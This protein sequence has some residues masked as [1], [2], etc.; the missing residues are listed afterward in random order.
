VR[1]EAAA[2]GAAETFT[3][4]DAMTDFA[5]ARRSNDGELSS[6]EALADVWSWAP[7]TADLIMR[8]PALN[9]ESVQAG[10][11]S[12]LQKVDSLGAAIVSGPAGLRVPLWVVT[13]LAVGTASEIA[14]RRMRRPGVDTAA[15]ASEEPMFSLPQGN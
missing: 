2:P 9:I 8:P 5:G 11:Q 12:F 10:V 14:R 7:Q 15:A 13:A 1:L 6:A 3:T 4:A